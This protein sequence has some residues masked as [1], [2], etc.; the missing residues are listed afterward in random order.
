MLYARK[1]FKTEKA[2]KAFQRKNG[3]A[4][5]SDIQGS[6]TR[7]DYRVEACIAE[8]TETQ[9]EGR[10]FCVAWNI[11]DEGPVAEDDQAGD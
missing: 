9:R 8:L 4:L 5:Y 2:A 6:R 1:F 3:G 7:E 10:P 11:V